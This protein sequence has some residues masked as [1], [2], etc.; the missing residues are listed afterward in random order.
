[1]PEKKMAGKS[2]A[3][4]AADLRKIRMGRKP[5][6]KQIDELNALLEEPRKKPAGSPKRK[7]A[8]PR[9]AET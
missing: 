5:T 7:S 8:R 2:L 1:M 9:D 6:A 4:L 3:T